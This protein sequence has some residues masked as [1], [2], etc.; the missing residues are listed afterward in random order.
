MM[1]ASSTASTAGPTAAAVTAASTRSV[2]RRSG[3]RANPCRRASRVSGP[4][5]RTVLT[6]ASLVGALPAQCASSR[7]IGRVVGHRLRVPASSPQGPQESVGSPRRL[8]TVPTMS[9]DSRRND[10]FAAVRET[11]IGVV[12]LVG[13][14]AY[15]LKKPV[16][17]TFLDFS[18]RQR[19]L[20]RSFLIFAALSGCDQPG[21]CVR[22]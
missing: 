4:G 2:L 8:P 7:V 22:P 19:R 9:A 11:H 17:T 1:V 3:E 6:A 10:P 14:L 12:F 15:K 18:T 16:R 13:E 21:W 5:T 20:D